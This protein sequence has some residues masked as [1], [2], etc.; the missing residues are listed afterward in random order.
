MAWP[1][2]PGSVTMSMDGDHRCFSTRLDGAAVEASVTVN[3]ADSDAS[4]LMVRTTADAPPGSH[5]ERL[6]LRWDGREIANLPLV[7]RIWP[8]PNAMSARKVL[9]VGYD[10]ARP[11]VLRAADTPV[12]D[13]LLPG[14]RYSF[15]ATTQRTWSTVSGPGWSSILTGVDVNKH[16]VL[17][18]DPDQFAARHTTWPSFIARAHDSGLTTAAV[19]H[20]IMIWTEFLLPEG[21]TTFG[22]TIQSDKLVAD[23][24]ADLLED[25]DY[26]VIFVHLD[27]PDHV[28]HDSGY[29]LDNPEYVKVHADCD[30]FLGEILD[31]LMSRSTFVDEHWLVAMTTD[32]GGIGTGHSER[33]AD[34]WTIWTVYASP[35]LTPGEIPTSGNP[36]HLDI[37]PTVLDFL[38]I[39]PVNDLDGHSRLR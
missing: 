29:S 39:E 27:D 30:A 20:W 31:G 32:H 3:P 16:N 9:V 22:E 35:D 34:T 7:A 17:G 8:T 5:S 25:E 15:A 12:L 6:D 10:G 36:S 21:K 13:G 19:V 37:H 24:T 38:G 2:R 11:D 23:R 4:I 26:D 1:G 28:G 18:N 14:S 33:S